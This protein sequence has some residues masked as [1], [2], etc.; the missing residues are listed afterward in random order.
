MKSVSKGKIPKKSKDILLVQIQIQIFRIFEPLNKMT[1]RCG[2]KKFITILVIFINPFNKLIVCVILLI[3]P[4]VT[5]PAICPFAGVCWEQPEVSGTGRTGTE[6]QAISF[7][8]GF[9][10]DWDE[11]HGECGCA[12]GRLWVG[13]LAGVPA[14]LPADVCFGGLGPVWVH[15]RHMLQSRLHHLRLC[16]FTYSHTLHAAHTTSE[17]TQHGHMLTNTPFC[18]YYLYLSFN[19]FFILY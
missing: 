6:Q 3:I 17:H 4:Y 16:V 5:L 11:G 9:G 15:A 14:L 12:T 1:L 10:A 13:G 7:S 8:S 19:P 2:L 18:Y